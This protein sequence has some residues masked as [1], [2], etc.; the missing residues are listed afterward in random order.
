MRV[1][2]RFRR[3]QP[4][5]DLDL[6]PGATAEDAVLMTGARARD[7]PDDRV[8]PVGTL[9]FCS[10]DLPAPSSSQLTPLSAL[11]SLIPGAGY[12][13]FTTVHLPADTIVEGCTYGGRVLTLMEARVSR[14]SRAR[15]RPRAHH[16]V[17]PPSPTQARAVEEYLMALH[18]NVHVD[19]TDYPGYL[20]RYV[21]D[22]LDD[23]G[24]RRKTMSIRRP[25]TPSGASPPRGLPTVAVA[26]GEELYA[27]YGGGTRRRLPRRRRGGGRHR[28]RS[29]SAREYLAGVPRVFC[30]SLGDCHVS[31]R[32]IIK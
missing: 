8:V 12:G 24:A 21:N 28:R 10:P 5:P 2:A 27:E 14:V 15:R 18:F 31:R 3:D 17:A 26:P 7:A 13:L 11:P 6:A 32:S 1:G 30:S 29:G 23:D 22:N 20:A 25:P 19:A 4:P 9:R 16:H